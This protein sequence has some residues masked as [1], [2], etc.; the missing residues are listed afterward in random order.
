MTQVKEFSERLNKIFSDGE[1]TKE[2]IID[3]YIK[4]N[5]TAQN[6]ALPIAGVTYST[7]Y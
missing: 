5:P 7:D 4:T 1:P 3:A 6:E 2:L